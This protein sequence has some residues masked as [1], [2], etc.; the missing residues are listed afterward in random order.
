MGFPLKNI[1]V[2]ITN[3][4]SGKILKNTEIGVIEVKGPN[5]FKGYWKMPEKTNIDFRSDGYFITGDLG[6][7]DGAGYI[8]ISGRDKDLIISGG[9]N[10]YPAEIE[11]AI[12]AAKT[13][14]NRSYTEPFSATEDLLPQTE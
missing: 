6:F 1:D 12:F 2:R 7:I 9:L 5:V 14:S 4:N 13:D 10:V 11:N 8:S 3:P